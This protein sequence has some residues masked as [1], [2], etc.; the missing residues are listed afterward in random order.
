MESI[1]PRGV[2]PRGCKLMPHKRWCSLVS[3]RD[4]QGRDWLVLEDDNVLRS[5]KE[6]DI[7]TLVRGCQKTALGPARFTRAQATINIIIIIALNTMTRMELTI[8]NLIIVGAVF[9]CSALSPPSG[10]VYSST[11]T[12]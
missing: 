8:W 5:L 9:K 4:I 6:I 2:S 12:S 3:C 11:L 1:L 10:Y 7:M